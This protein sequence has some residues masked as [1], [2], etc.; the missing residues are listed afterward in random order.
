MG[1]AYIQKSSGPK[2]LADVKV[3]PKQVIVT[4]VEPD[5]KGQPQVFHIDRMNSPEGVRNGRFNVAL[6]EDKTTLFDLLPVGGKDE[7]GNKITYAATFV[8]IAHKPDNLPMPTNDDGRT[9]SFIDPRTGN[10]VN[11]VEPPSRVFT[12]RFRILAGDYRGLIVPIRLRY[13]FSQFNDTQEAMVWAE[14]G[15]PWIQ[16]GKQLLS[17][18]KTAGFDMSS[19]IF[20]WSQDG[21]GTLVSL[22]KL[23][24][25]KKLVVNLEVSKSGWV[26]KVLPGAEG[27]TIETF[28]KAEPK[29]KKMKMVEVE[30]DEE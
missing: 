8:E 3:S 11:R 6:N 12:L 16:W 1:R 26:N 30:D 14:G 15:Q 19:D 20:V 4:M 7:S 10:V 17:T 2:G 22:D 29:T 27:L 24:K 13:L 28:D 5:E 18:V 23:L 21:I 9:Y 25:S